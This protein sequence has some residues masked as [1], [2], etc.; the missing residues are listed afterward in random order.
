MRQ[1]LLGGSLD[2][3]GQHGDCLDGLFALET[4]LDDPV[5]D[6]HQR[7]VCAGDD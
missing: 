1:E 4:A 2:G 6:D 3:G 5:T 7:R